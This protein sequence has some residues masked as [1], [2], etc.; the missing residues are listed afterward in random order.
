MKKTI[1]L[2]L[3]L[4][5]CM[6]VKVA[7]ADFTFGTPRNIGP[8]VNNSGIAIGPGISADG[9]ELYFMSFQRSDGF[10]S[11]DIYVTTRKTTDDDWGEPKNLGPIVNS[12]NGEFDPS[13]SGDGLSL[14]FSDGLWDVQIPRPG[15]IGGGDI[16]VTRRETLSDPWGIPENL[17][18]IVNSSSTEGGP[19]ISADGLA[20]FFES[21]RAGGPGTW[22][23]W[24]TTRA[25]VSDP[26]RIPVNLGPAVNSPAFDAHPEISSDGLALFF[27]SRRSG[28]W[29]IWM[30]TRADVSDAFGLP[31]NIGQMIYN[32]VNG[33]P[34]ISSDGRLLYFTPD[35]FEIWQVPITP[36]VD[37]NSDGIVD[38]AD[39][40]IMV[41]HWGEDYSLCDVGPMPW[42][43]GIVDVQ[44]LIVLA[45]HLFEEFP[46]AESAQ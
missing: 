28:P 15:G 41:D 22:N 44:D 40:C 37:F 36:I 26:W 39:I 19:G 8:A 7:K 32:G 29:D 25:S 18:S 35:K 21:N 43:D 3:V 30:T 11:C 10:G 16:W 9:L 38:S 13:I 45:E 27:Q 5:L 42:G 4:A 1:S 31:V 34:S 20:L 6:V 2:M 33:F 46:P 24:V 14:Y 12:P 17:G 23:L